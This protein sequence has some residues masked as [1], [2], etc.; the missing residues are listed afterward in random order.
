MKFPKNRIPKSSYEYGL[1]ID[2]LLNLR[3][4]I[5]TYKISYQYLA[6]LLELNVEDCE[7][8]ID[9]KAGIPQNL[10]CRIQKVNNYLMRTI[11]EIQ[12]EVFSNK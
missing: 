7:A 3:H 2:A 12:D 4:L 8:I 6:Y 1:A 10:I 9:N 11:E 5:Y